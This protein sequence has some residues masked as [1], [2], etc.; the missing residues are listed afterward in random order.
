MKYLALLFPILLIA[1]CNSQPHYKYHYHP[2][3]PIYH[4]DYQPR[5]VHHVVHHVYHHKYSRVNLRKY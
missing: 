3:H 5:T 4:Y 2:V 1:G